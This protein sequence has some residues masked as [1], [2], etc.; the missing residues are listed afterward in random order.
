MEEVAS[1]LATRVAKN[2]SA[3]PK[4]RFIIAMAGGPGSGKSTLAQSVQKDLESSHRLSCQ[5]VEL[6]GFMFSKAQLDK[7]P[8]PKRAH[9]RRGSVWTFDAH[10]VVNFIR[11]VR[12]QDPDAGT[13]GGAVQA[14][15][16]DEEKLDPVPEGEVV[17]PETQVVIFE[18]IYFLSDT[19]PWNEVQGLVDDRWFVHVRPE[20]SRERVAR[21]RYEKGIS[22][23]LEESYRFYDQS[24]GKNNEFIIQNRGEV[25]LI[26]ENNEDWSVHEP[27]E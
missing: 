26:I 1:Q 27:E 14:P 2:Y 8:D 7:F 15:L 23:D 19:E 3:A 21:R 4:H 12:H 22:G 5:T 6:D 24:D 25:D 18:G 16:Y 11:K 13:E 20:V 10:G 17:R 9:E